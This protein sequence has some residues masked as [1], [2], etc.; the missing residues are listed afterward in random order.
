VSHLRVLIPD[1]ISLRLA[2]S[3]VVLSTVSAVQMFVRLAACG[4]AGAG[5]GPAQP[6][7]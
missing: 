2:S 4:R 1:D 6:H 5:G 7:S 3:S